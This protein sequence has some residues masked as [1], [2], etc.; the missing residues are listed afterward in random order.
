MTRSGSYSLKRKAPHIAAYS[1][2]GAGV[3]K[4]A[5]RGWDFYNSRRSKRARYSGGSTYDSRSTR[6]FPSLG[7]QNILNAFSSVSQVMTQRSRY[8]NETQEGCNS[9]SK[10]HYGTVKCHVPMSVVNTLQ[11]QVK[12]FNYAQ[13]SISTVG[14]QQQ[15]TETFA[16]P[17]TLLAL[18]PSIN[19][20]MILHAI[21][22]ELT[23]VNASSTNSSM[24]IY[25]LIAKRDASVS[26]I[27]TP[28]NAWQKGVDDAGGSSTD[29]TIVGSIPTESVAFN[30]F[31]RIIQRTRI[32]LAPGEMH[33]HEFTYFPN[34][35]LSGELLNGVAYQ[36]A[37]ITGNIMIVHHGMP[38]HDSTTTTS[39]T[40]DISSL[41]LVMKMSYDW[42]ELEN[43]V[44]SWSKTNNLGTSFA[45]GEQFVNEAV[46]QVQDTG[47]LHPGT[48]HS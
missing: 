24:T 9:L 40:V 10:C 12:V 23:L 22:G 46:G 39:V 37:G 13:N 41:D 35:V 5:K 14:T 42:R 3:Y 33:R 4:A 8:G 30:D 15:F 16:D 45:V 2:F 1:G 25:N 43:S 48:L 28:V 11:R 47:G 19:D 38:A 32:S 18:L 20:K 34:K 27:S 29:L 21:K 36:L 7:S 6:I 17:A 31:Y 26:V 44:T